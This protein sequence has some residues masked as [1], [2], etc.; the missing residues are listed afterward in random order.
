MAAKCP[1]YL[2]LS[3]GEK[4]RRLYLE[5]EHEDGYYR[6]RCVFSQLIDIEDRISL[7]V[8]Y[9]S[10]A[11]MSYSLNSFL[12]YEGYRLFV[13]GTEGRLEM[14]VRESSYISGDDSVQG[15]L[16][17]GSSLT[18]FPLFGAPRAI[19]LPE[20][21]GGHG[22]GDR[23]LLDDVFCDEPRPDPLKHAAT[24]I[25]GAYSILTGI[26]A[27]RSI[28]TGQAVKVDSLVRF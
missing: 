23:L 3:A 15:E 11:I 9:A 21:K 19:E 24:E 18:I 4:M 1:Y 13:N 14:F 17:P 7:S 20:A 10:G 27:N 25:D 8:R 6:D 12:P 2:D 16:L 28:A 26:A 5:A 22:G